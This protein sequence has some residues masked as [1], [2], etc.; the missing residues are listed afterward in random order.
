MDFSRVEHNEETPVADRAALSKKIEQEIQKQDEKF[1]VKAIIKDRR[2]PN[3]RRILCRNEEELKKVKSAATITAAEGARV[4]RDQLYPVKV[5][6]A[7]ADALLMPDG[8]LKASA[9]LEI[10]TENQ[11][12]LSQGG[13]VEQEAK[14]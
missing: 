5:N 3:R 11:T 12:E 1:W 13:L 7:R 10:A 14:W 2:S 8:T 9:A 4:L 6:N